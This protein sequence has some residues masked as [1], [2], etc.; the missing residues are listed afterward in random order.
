MIMLL[1]I[2]QKSAGYL[3]RWSFL[4]TKFNFIQPLEMI[5]RAPL[6]ASLKYLLKF[7]YQSNKINTEYQITAILLMMEYLITRYTGNNYS[8][9][10]YFGNI[11]TDMM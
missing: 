5:S 2:M 10:T 1:Q 3:W 4:E 11:E 9:R 8:K 7:G 6:Y